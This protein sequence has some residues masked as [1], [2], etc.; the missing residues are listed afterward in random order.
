[1]VGGGIVGVTTADAAGNVKTTF[2]VPTP[3][4]TGKSKNDQGYEISLV[5]DPLTAT[6]TFRSARVLGGL[7]PEQRPPRD[8]SACASSAYGFA[9]RRPPDSRCRRS[10]CTTSIRGARCAGRSHSAPAPPRAARSRRR[11]C[12]SSFPFNPRSGQW[13]LQFDTNPG[14]PPGH[15]A[16]ARFLFSTLTLTVT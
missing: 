9:S 5:Q 10:T 8:A 15:P 3:P 6:A 1:M 14:V 11:R 4:L 7:Q 13:T 12:A 2:P 16:S